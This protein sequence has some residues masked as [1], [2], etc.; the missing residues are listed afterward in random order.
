VTEKKE[1]DDRDED[2]AEI[3]RMIDVAQRDFDESGGTMQR[4]KH[5][6]TFAFKERLE[7][8]Q[9]G[10]EGMGDFECVRAGLAGHR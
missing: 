6:N 9:R 1:Q 4:R 7:I 10:F 3:K 5:L 2:G 8:V